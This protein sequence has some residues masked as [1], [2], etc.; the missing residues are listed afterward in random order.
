MTQIPEDQVT[1]NDLMQWYKIQEELAKLKVSEMLLRTRC[2]KHY[3]PTPE[4]GTNTAPLSD[5]YALKGKRT[6]NRKI[7]RPQLTVLE[8]VFRTAAL[9]LDAL[10][11]YEPEL[12][13]KEYR[14]LT[15]EQLTLFDQCMEIKDGAPALEVVL[16]KR[17]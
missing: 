2:F 12:V 6:I 10:I 16:P 7:L 14:T 11:K 8:P 4:E 13:I 9:P 15:K 1:I 17:K 3:F 5:G